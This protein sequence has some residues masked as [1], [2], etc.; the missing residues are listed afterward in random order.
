MRWRASA[1]ISARSY[2]RRSR[3]EDQPGGR[4]RRCSAWVRAVVA[5][6]AA[7]AAR[8]A[9]ED[10]ALMERHDAAVEECGPGEGPRGGGAEPAAG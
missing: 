4:G 7:S 9:K 5:A 10:C 1:G 2:A 6:Y 8:G 3:W